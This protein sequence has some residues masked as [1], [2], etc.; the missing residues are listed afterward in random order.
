MSTQNLPDRQKLFIAVH[1][2]DQQTHLEISTNEL[3]Q[4][5]IQTM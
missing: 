1:R 4:I 3:A 2:A 5:V